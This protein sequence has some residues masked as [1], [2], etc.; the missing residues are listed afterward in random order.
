MLPL[1]LGALLRRLADV[2]SEYALWVFGAN[3]FCICV[4]ANVV[5]KLLEKKSH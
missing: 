2:A 1:G 5:I 3:G 4:P